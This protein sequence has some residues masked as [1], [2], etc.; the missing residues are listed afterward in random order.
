MSGFPDGARS[1]WLAQALLNSE[2]YNQARRAA[3][4]H[5]LDFR[6]NRLNFR[7]THRASHA[8]VP[9]REPRFQRASGESDV[10]TVFWGS[11]RAGV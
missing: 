4:A 3:W 2:G 9:W 11:S 5:H 8:V 1:G 10:G 7:T 6:T